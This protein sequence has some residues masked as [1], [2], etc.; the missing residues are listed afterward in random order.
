[1]SNVYLCQIK[2]LDWSYAKVNNFNLHIKLGSQNSP[3]TENSRQ[4]LKNS[5]NSQKL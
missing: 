4:K 2:G 1:M 5:D 3:R